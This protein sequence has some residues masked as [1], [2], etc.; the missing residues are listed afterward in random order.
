MQYVFSV[1]SFIVGICFFF[2]YLEEQKQKD[3]LDLFYRDSMGK[4]LSD[5][6]LPGKSA[7][8]FMGLSF[9]LAITLLII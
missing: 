7:L 1:I 9:L 6:S 5:Y 2:A 4:F 3:S 8:W